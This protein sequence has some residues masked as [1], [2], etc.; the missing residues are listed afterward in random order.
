MQNHLLEHPTNNSDVKRLTN[1]RRSGRIAFHD[2]VPPIE[3]EIFDDDLQKAVFEKYPLIPYS[4]GEKWTSHKMLKTLYAFKNMSPTFGGI[5]EDIKTYALKGKIQLV[6]NED[7]VFDLGDSRDVS[8]G[9]KKTF[10]DTLNK[11]FVFKPASIKGLALMLSECWDAVGMLGVMVTTQEI[12]GVMTITV[13]YIHPTE[14]MFAKVDV[15]GT[16]VAISRRWD[17]TWLRKNP[18]LM[19][20]TFPAEAEYENGITR[21]FFYAKNGGLLYGR[22]TDMSA[23][24]PKYSE[25][26]LV[27]YLTKKNKGLWL[28]NVL[29]ETED[30]EHGGFIDDDAARAEG[31]DSSADR[32]A[33]NFTNEGDDPLAIVATSR[34]YGAKPM[35][36]HE[37]EGLKNADQ[38]RQYFELCER[39]IIVANNWSKML[40]TLEGASGF[41][42][43]V[44]MDTFAIKSVTKIFDRQTM[45]K[46]FLGR[47]ITYGHEKIG[48]TTELAPAFSSPLN[49][50]YNEYL[51]R[52]PGNKALN[53]GEGVG[54]Q[55][56]TDLPSPKAD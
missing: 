13:R 40:L 28:P 42:E 20:P 3:D 46:E 1:S 9:E 47:I 38:V 37:F 15:P 23:L 21:T 49:K 34:P 10:V 8:P 6:Y 7:P 26:K 41:S 48:L 54:R 29:L 33:I 52:N 2:I 25:Y 14:W 53:S 36:V 30:S 22:P 44:F 27:Q 35:F 32:L 12:L 55:T 43:K 16:M 18:P 17:D 19:V 11:H 56:A 39:Q 50:L 51:E 24:M 5:V 4:A 31:Y 45:L